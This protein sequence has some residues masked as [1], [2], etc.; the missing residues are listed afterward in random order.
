M[1]SLLRDFIRDFSRAYLERKIQEKAYEFGDISHFAIQILEQFPEVRQAFQERYHE[2]MVDEYQ[3]TNHTQ[4]RM[5]DLLS[6]GHN[7]F[8][9]GISSNRFIASVR[10]IHR[11]SMINLK[12]TKKKG[13]KGG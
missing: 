5:L 1:L 13:R 7:R 3:D 12:P 4:E 9:V 8:M 11:F 6:N 10:Q 2:V